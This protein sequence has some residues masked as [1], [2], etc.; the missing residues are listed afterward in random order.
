[1]LGCLPREIRELGYP[2]RS[3]LLV[4]YINHGRADAE[5]S[6]IAP[7]K[8]AQILLARPDNLTDG[9]GE[10]AARLSSACPEMKALAGLRLRSVHGARTY[11]RN[12]PE[13]PARFRC[14]AAVSLA[15]GKILQVTLP[16]PVPPI[17]AARKA[18][19]NSCRAIASIV[20]VCDVM[21]DLVL[22]EALSGRF[23]S[24]VSLASPPHDRGVDL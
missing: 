13:P 11:I 9:Q 14:P 8:A 12:K 22:G 15:S 3:N 24:P 4:R 18:A 21:P 20:R 19:L 7:R 16:C 2:G 17:F 5:R 1:L 10:T 23:R 6:Q